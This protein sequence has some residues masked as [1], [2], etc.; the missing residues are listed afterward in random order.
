[1][2]LVSFCMAGVIILKKDSIPG[3]IRR[4]LALIASILVFVSFA[5][6]VLSFLN[7]RPE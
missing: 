4:P 3:R 6:L 2:L 7:M 1:M 5:L